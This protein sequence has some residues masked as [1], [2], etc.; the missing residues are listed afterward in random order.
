VP[1]TNYGIAISHLHGLLDRVL[2]PFR[3]E[4]D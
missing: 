4:L 3:D 2:V 1:V